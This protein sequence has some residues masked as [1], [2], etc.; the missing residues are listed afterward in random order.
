VTQS[1]FL[2]TSGS[3]VLTW[4]VHAGLK[5]AVQS[6]E[7]QA[8][9]QRRSVSSTSANVQEGIDNAADT[10]KAGSRQAEEYA[11]EPEKVT[12]TMTF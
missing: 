2:T 3:Q 10:V 5:D 7:S 11:A 6:T 4:V 1:S 8:G 9:S 12:V